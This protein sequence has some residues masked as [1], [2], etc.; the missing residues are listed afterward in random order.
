VVLLLV[1]VM[2]VMRLVLM[3][4]TDSGTVVVMAAVLGGKVGI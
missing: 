3:V 4:G 1:M 2:L